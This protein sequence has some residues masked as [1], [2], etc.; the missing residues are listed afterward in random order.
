MA[1]SSLLT[2][3]QLRALARLKAL[4][5]L[6][7]FYLAGGT[8]VAFHLGHRVS[9]DLDLFGS[10]R[11]VDLGSLQR[12]LTQH[13]PDL[14]VLAISAATLQVK[15]EGIPIDLVRY[16]YAPLE[17][18]ET[19]PEGFAVA[20]RMDLAVMKLAAIAHRGLR[21]DFW[22]LHELITRG[23]V[24]L[25]SAL[26]AYLRRFGKAEPDL[27]H[28]LRSLTFFEDAEQEALMPAGLTTAH[29][30]PLRQYFLT[31]APKML[32]ARTQARSSD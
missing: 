28:V 18:T 24:S 19:G 11:E 26:D 12:S 30:E 3:N 27:Y 25:D 5:A 9:R 22:D 21:R 14:E 32:R 13:L 29:W 10:I 2:P 15:L 16:A 7:P 6:R 20:G 31:E 8:A 23:G 1:D 4:D 17:P